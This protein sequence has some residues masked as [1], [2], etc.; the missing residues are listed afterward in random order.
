[1]FLLVC[2][3]IFSQNQLPQPLTLFSYPNLGFLMTHQAS[4]L[5]SPCS[6][7]NLFCSL[8]P[9]CSLSVFVS[10][11]LHAG[12]HLFG[13]PLFPQSGSYFLPHLIPNLTLFRK[14]PQRKFPLYLNIF[15][16]V[17]AFWIGLGLEGDHYAHTLRYLS[18]HLYFK[19][20]YRHSLLKWD[21]RN[22][23]VCLGMVFPWL[24]GSVIEAQWLVELGIH[25]RPARTEKT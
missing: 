20:R 1:M 8:P 16:I 7:S 15:F 4:S 17:E 6:S 12:L 21:G 9:A 25:S 3:F 22:R 18:P 10:E 23:T 2:S 5:H 13:I 11:P 14:L 19:Q 24:L